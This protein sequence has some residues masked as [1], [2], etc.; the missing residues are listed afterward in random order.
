MILRSVIS[1]GSHDSDKKWFLM[2]TQTIIFFFFFFFFIC[3]MLQNLPQETLLLIVQHLGLDDKLSLV[4]TCQGLKEIIS[5]TLLYQELDFCSKNDALLDAL[6]YFESRPIY[7]SQVQRIQFYKKSIT[8]HDIGRIPAV[9]PN[10][11]EF[12]SDWSFEGGRSS[13]YEM[14]KWKDTLE[15]A[16]LSIRTNK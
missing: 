9:F 6:E 8:N 11:R 10:V 1:K 13:M 7:S 4:L 16:I 15:I 12:T 2:K 3:Q 14:L 5:N